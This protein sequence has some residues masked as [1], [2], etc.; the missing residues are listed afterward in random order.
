MTKEK[1]IQS[2][3]ADIESI[4]PKV[5]SRLPWSK[6]HEAADQRQVLERV[7]S[8]LISVQ[9][10]F[11]AASEPLPTNSLSQQPP[12]VQQLVQA[13]TR[14]M[15]VLRADLIKPLQA[16]LAALREERESLIREIRQ[17]E[18]ARREASD[19][20]SQQKADQEQKISEFA[21]DAINRT[22][23]SVTQQLAQILVNWEAQLLNKEVTPETKANKGATVLS[24]PERMEQ[25]RQ[26]QAQFDGMLRTID[27]NHRAI[28]DTLERDIHG[29]QDSLSLGLDKMHRLG[30]QGELLFT[31]LVN[32]LAQLLGRE[33]STLLQSSRE[34]SEVTHPPQ[35]I[36][37]QPPPEAKQPQSAL[38]FTDPNIYKIPE[39]LAG[40]SLPLTS[41]LVPP[42]VSP[43]TDTIHQGSVEV[44]DQL[45]QEPESVYPSSG[46]TPEESS[47]DSLNFQDWEPIEGL[48]TENLDEIDTENLDENDGIET[49]IQLN[50]HTKEAVSD[51]E[52]SS[53]PNNPDTQE[54]DVLLGSADENL[55]ELSPLDVEAEI[56]DVAAELQ[57]TTASHHLESEDLYENLF[58]TDELS[59]APADALDLSSMGAEVVL[60]ENHDAEAIEVLPSQAQNLELQEFSSLETSEFLNSSIANSFPVEEFL[61]EGLSDPATEPASTAPPIEAARHLAEFLLENAVA[62]SVLKADL[63]VEEPL[64]KPTISLPASDRQAVGEQDAPE[65]IS[66]LTDLLDQMGL[67]YSRPILETPLAYTTREEHWSPEE[68]LETEPPVRQVEERYI[69]ASPDENLLAFDELVNKSERDIQ[70]DRNTLQQLSKDLHSFEEPEPEDIPTQEEQVPSS[71]YWEPPTVA[72]TQVSELGDLQNQ[73]FPM[74]EELLAEDWEE[75]ALHDLSH[76]DTIFPSWESG[77]ILDLS[78][79]EPDPARGYLSVSRRG[80][81]VE[82]DPAAAKSA[83]SDSD[84]EDFLEEYLDSDIENMLWEG[85]FEEMIPFDENALSEGEE[86][87]GDLRESP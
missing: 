67:S 2:L 13:V 76:E 31:A 63:A 53:I 6:P 62:D 47:L 45:H 72:P 1:D 49:F 77:A 85:R 54:L 17:L 81:D 5:G 52:D 68:A 29:Y 48:D 40:P 23:E 9:Q 21:R 79:P 86:D 24:L 3:L 22:T 41:L 30:V 27:G 87:D 43:I 56:P 75:F 11:R 10:N 4:L 69:S 20:F 35:P 19:S 37:N 58:G 66:S 83:P 59:T 51:F 26:L 60:E 70:L 50:L 65:T 38:D 74:S 7:R 12:A 25:L 14:E 18:N 32:R 71:Y 46:S 16:E 28:F 78:T 39:T 64:V 80:E 8:Y 42:S 61:F 15:E 55:A 36:P 73:P 33:A 57:P 84:V 82:I 34:L 44:P